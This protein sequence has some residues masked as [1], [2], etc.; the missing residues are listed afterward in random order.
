MEADL[1]TREERGIDIPGSSS[2]NFTEVQQ[3]GKAC[4]CPRTSTSSTA[5]LFLFQQ[6]EALCLFWWGSHYTVAVGRLPSSRN[7]D[8]RI[9]HWFRIEEDV[10]FSILCSRSLFFFEFITKICFRV[11]LRALQLDVARG[12]GRGGKF[13]TV[14]FYGLSSRCGGQKTA[15]GILDGL[16]RNAT[17]PK[18]RPADGPC[19]AR[20]K[21]RQGGRAETRR[22]SSPSRP[23]PA[24]RPR[25][26]G[27]PGHSHVVDAER[28]GAAS[29]EMPAL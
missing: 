13:L 21:E 20:K 3:A 6:G 16:Q 26:R 11:V 9:P 12:R 7:I 5:T 29:T 2:T 23:L 18:T 24:Y 4:R 10:S 19:G 15:K 25:R 28:E 8:L 1:L 27:P 22:G 17:V 14:F